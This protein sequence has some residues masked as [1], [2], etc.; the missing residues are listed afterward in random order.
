MDEMSEE[1]MSGPHA[2][3]RRL[4]AYREGRLSEAEREALQEHL[5]LCPRCTGLL[6]ELRDFE[7]AAAGAVEP[8]P[9]ALRQQ[10]WESL[11]RKLPRQSPAPR[12]RPIAT[13]P[14]R[15]R[16]ATRYFSAI[17]AALLLVLGGLSFWAV[18]QAG[19]E[20]ERLAEVEQRLEEREAALAQEQRARA[21]AERQLR[22]ARGQLAAL[23]RQKPGE[24]PENREAGLEARIAEL[25]ATVEEHRRAAS[26]R[27]ATA[28]PSGIEVST[29]PRFAL[30]GQEEDGY[31]KPGGAVNPIPRAERLT[32]ALS[33]GNGP[34]YGEYRFEL[35]DPQGKVLW[36][37]RRP[38]SSLLGDAGT[39][40]SIR[41]L[42]PGRYRLRAEGLNPDRTELLGE[43]LLEII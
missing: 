2:G 18:I 24:P 38:A 15:R 34:A 6:R 4:I 16:P 39:T 27:I 17:A 12:V 3:T 41:G 33:L 28:A 11:S 21:E 35:T 30:R 26:Q 31:L 8:G 7:A 42:A 32:A 9:D 1:P 14:A 5:S 40:L 19:Q 13:L 36:S 29:T 20:R 43:Y 25:E 22:A 23:R 37:G 10:A